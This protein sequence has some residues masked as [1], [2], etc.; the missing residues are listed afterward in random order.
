M[1][2]TMRTGLA[3][4]VG[5]DR[6]YMFGGVQAGL[7][8]KM[9]TFFLSK[10]FFSRIKGCTI[11]S[12]PDFDSDPTALKKLLYVFIVIAFFFR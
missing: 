2:P 1:R 11:V 7:L 3:T 12:D 8:Q 4:A 10:C 5:K 9:N 6:M